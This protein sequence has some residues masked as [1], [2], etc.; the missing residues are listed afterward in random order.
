MCPI[1]EQ[2]PFRN[3]VRVHVRSFETCFKAL[4][5][6]S[7]RRSPVLDPELHLHLVNAMNRRAFL[8]TGAALGASAAAR[9]PANTE[10]VYRFHAGDCDIRM[11]VEF[12][13]NYSTNGFWFKEQRDSRR[14]CL[15]GAGQE[16]RNC[17]A[18][19]TGSIAIAR[20]HIQPLSHAPRA[21]ALREHVRAIDQDSR[22][23]TREPFERTINLENGVASD[24][25]AFGYQADA[26]PSQESDGPNGPWCLLRQDLYLEGPGALFLVLHWK[27][28]LN[29]IRLFDVIPGDRTRLLAEPDASP[30]AS[31]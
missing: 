11:V 3:R 26:S 19:F 5:S 30:R 23:M 6:N 20:Y 2:R 31:R 29:A 9:K 15:S 7:P 27:H 10:T 28:T 12:F 24:I 18:N 25:Q 22:L 17:L 14:F 1:R 21:L 16:N 4:V 8:W 13:D